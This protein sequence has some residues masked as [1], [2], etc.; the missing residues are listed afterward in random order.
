[1]S[2]EVEKRYQDMVVHE[3]NSGKVV[4]Q[5]HDRT[6]KKSKLGVFLSKKPQPTMALVVWEFYANA[7]DNMVLIVFVLGK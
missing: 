3:L 2:E 7:N 5:L 4:R 6:I 1:M